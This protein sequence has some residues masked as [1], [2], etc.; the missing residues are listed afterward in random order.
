MCQSSTVF[1]L[2]E[3]NLSL[4]QPNGKSTSDVARRKQTWELDLLSALFPA[5]VLTKL[6][7]AGEIDNTKLEK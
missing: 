3:A 1:L 2:L 4:S 7:H 6:Y 5:A